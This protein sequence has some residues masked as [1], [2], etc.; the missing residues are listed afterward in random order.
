MENDAN[1]EQA[2]A[3]FLPFWDGLDPQQQSSLLAST[4]AARYPAGAHVH[5]G[6]GDC[7]GVLLVKSGSLR[8]YLLSPTGR[9][10]TL[11]HVR[12]GESCVL[13]ASCVL[14]MIT[15]DLFLDAESD[16]EIYAIDPDVFARVVEGNVAAEAF[17]YRQTAERFSDVMW[18][19][20]QM[21]FMS[22]DARLAVFLLDEVARQG[23]ADL[24]VTHDQIARNIGSAREA[25]SRMLGQ[26]ADR[27]IVK[28]GR[29][30]I[31]VCDKAVLRRLAQEGS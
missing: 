26:L 29:G 10:C 5:N 3:E 16:C 30:R 25:V 28:L 23:S 9:E 22:L 14:Q 7:I 1:T 18:V 6:E 19:L 15:F 11:F 2:L 12:A 20:N 13:A 8:A 24:R 4:R 31:Q 21:V 17:T 27:G